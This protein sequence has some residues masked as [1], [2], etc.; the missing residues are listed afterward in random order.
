MAK[1]ETTLTLKDDVSAVF[2]RL[3]VNLNKVFDKQAEIAK[4][5]YDNI[6]LIEKIIDKDS[7]IFK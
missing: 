5:L 1:L 2:K 7:V 3:D 4:L 6:V